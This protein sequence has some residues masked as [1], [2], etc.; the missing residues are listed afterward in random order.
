MSTTQ[1]EQH[2]YSSPALGVQQ[3]SSI[4]AG[5]T[6]AAHEHHSK[7]SGSSFDEK[8]HVPEKDLAQ[9]EVLLANANADREG[10]ENQA[11]R[12]ARYRRFR[13]FILAALVV[14]IGGWWISSIV[15]PATRHRWYVREKKIDITIFYFG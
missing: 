7:D 9:Q 14:V 10:D 4:P 3:R 13:P 5:Q 8:A 1:A 12:E 11:A 2:P 15:L 6:E